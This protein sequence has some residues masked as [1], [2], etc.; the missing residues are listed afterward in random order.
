MH[1]SIAT[2]YFIHGI[3][4]AQH[5]SPLYR[6]CHAVPENEYHFVVDRTPRCSFWLHIM[7]KLSLALAFPSQEKNTECF[8]LSH[9]NTP[10]SKSNIVFSPII[11]NYS[12][13]II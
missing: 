3:N 10:G 6:I 7:D 12:Y 9:A 13:I 8:A 1:S 2:Q 11:Q 5:G 4:P